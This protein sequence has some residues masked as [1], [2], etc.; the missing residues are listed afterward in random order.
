MRLDLACVK[1]VCGLRLALSI[2]YVDDEPLIPMAED[3][4]PKK[5]RNEFNIKRK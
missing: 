2:T 3:R 5:Y 1:F 4:A